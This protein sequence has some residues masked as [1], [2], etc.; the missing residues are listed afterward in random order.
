E[1][2]AKP[3]SQA[4][5]LPIAAATNRAAPRQGTPNASIQRFASWAAMSAAGA[6]TRW[7]A[8]AVFVSRAGRENAVLTE[9][10]PCRGVGYLQDTCSVNKV[11]I[12]ARSAQ[13][14]VPIAAN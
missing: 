4:M 10:S 12:R 8:G 14:L 2:S 11:A 1:A 7:S 9:G 6:E 3:S 13:A 5:P